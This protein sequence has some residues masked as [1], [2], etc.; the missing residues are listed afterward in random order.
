MQIFRRV[1]VEIASCLLGEANILIEVEWELQVMLTRSDPLL[2][3]IPL[4]G[5]LLEDPVEVRLFQAA[6][7][8]DEH[9]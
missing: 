8:T 4:L 5:L 2:P 3:P 6:R 1:D 7:S 9:L